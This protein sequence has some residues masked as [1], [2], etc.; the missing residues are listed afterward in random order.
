[1]ST[2]PRRVRVRA[3]GCEHAD[4]AARV[5]ARR[6]GRSGRGPLRRHQ[7]AAVRGRRVDRCRAGCPGQAARGRAAGARRRA[8][9][10]GR[11]VHGQLPRG[12]AD[13]PGPLAD[14]RRRHSAAVPAQRGRAAARAR[15][16]RRRRG[17]DDAGV[18]A[19]GHR[20]D[21]RPGRAPRA[22]RAGG[23]RARSPSPSSTAGDEA[24][25]RSVDPS[26]MAALLY[27]GGTTGRSKGVVLS[28]DALS[29]AAWAAVRS[30]ERRR[31]RRLTRCRCRSRTR[32]GCSCRRSACTPFAR[33]GPC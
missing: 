21:G 29:T 4:A 5:V 2:D 9:R 3:L 11:G 10:P 26:S 25:L 28:H 7:H 31:I 8:R 15:R 13:L 18:P 1:M 23:R 19:Q 30:G 17:R 27:T 33:P 12:V 32:T 22:G 14:R 20:G 6:A 16:L 24:S